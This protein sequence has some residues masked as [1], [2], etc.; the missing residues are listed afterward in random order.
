[1]KEEKETVRRI[2]GEWEDVEVTKYRTEDGRLFES[3][4]DAIK[5][6]V[7]MTYEKDIRFTD[8]TDDIE[9]GDLT[10]MFYFDGNNPDRLCS[11]LCVKNTE[12]L[13]SP[14]WYV[15]KF[16]DGGDSKDATIIQP[17]DDFIANIHDYLKM[18]EERKSC[19]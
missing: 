10:R 15:Y 18:I 6:E 5:H 8:I 9:F 13:T 12:V 1:M 16:Y 19:A 14:G 2:V 7:S 4:R 17:L 11:Y 3:E